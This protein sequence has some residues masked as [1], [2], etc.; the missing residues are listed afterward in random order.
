MDILG[1]AGMLNENRLRLLMACER[2]H[3]GPWGGDCEALARKLILLG[4]AMK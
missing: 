1:D 2:D 4:R 3:D